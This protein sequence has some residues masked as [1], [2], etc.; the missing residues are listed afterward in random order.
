MN[1]LF[2]FLKSKPFFVHLGF[3]ILTITILFFI[4]IKWLNSYTSH[5]NL[6]NVPDFKGKQIIDLENFLSDKKVSYLIIDSIYDPNEKPGVVIKQ[7]PE[8]NSKVKENR[9]IYLYVTG[10]VPPQIQMPKLIDRSERQARLII[11]TY[12]LKLGKVTEK[13]ADCNGCVIG[14]VINGKD[15]NPGSTVKKG[16]VVDLTVGFKDELFS[17][18]A[19]ADSTNK[20]EPDFNNDIE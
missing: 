8:Y 9:T 3:I 5:G 11:Q 2:S 1:N 20:D 15:V 7:E 10:N 13:R 14:Q 19:T 18:S 16:S 6:I 17:S 12:G 4:T